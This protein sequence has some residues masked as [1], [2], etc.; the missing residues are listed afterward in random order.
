MRPNR[1]AAGYPASYAGLRSAEQGLVRLRAAVMVLCSIKPGVAP[2][3]QLRRL[4]MGQRLPSVS[5]ACCPPLRLLQAT[6]VPTHQPAPCQTKPACNC[7]PLRNAERGDELVERKPHY[8]APLG[9]DVPER[10]AKRQG[11]GEA[12]ARV[13]GTGQAGAAGAGRQGVRLLCCLGAAP[14]KR[15]VPTP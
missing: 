8:R 10:P 9:D 13:V 14:V 12:E 2:H 11:C 7:H 3:Y 6:L 1:T 15:P 5:N 4:E